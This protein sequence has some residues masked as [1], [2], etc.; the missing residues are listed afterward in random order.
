MNQMTTMNGKKYLD[1]SKYKPIDD[2]YT[3]MTFE[4]N[5]FKVRTSLHQL[6]KNIKYAKIDLIGGIYFI[7]YKDIHIV[8][9]KDDVMTFTPN[10]FLNID[11]R[12]FKTYNLLLRRLNENG[13]FLKFLNKVWVLCEDAND[14]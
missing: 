4:V 3:G 2:M 10:I 6:M 1:R 8:D 7:K 12:V 5:K 9:I 11:I 13:L 14:D